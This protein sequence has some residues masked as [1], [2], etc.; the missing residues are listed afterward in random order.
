MRR[1]EGGNR[2]A[3]VGEWD[4]S[5]ENEYN[6]NR[7]VKILI[8]NIIVLIAAAMVIVA[9]DDHDSWADNYV[10]NFAD[11]ITDY[12]GE[13]TTMRLDDGRQFYITSIRADVVSLLGGKAST[14]TPDSAYRCV[15]IYTCSDSTARIANLAP[16]FAPKPVADSVLMSI[17]H[18]IKTDPCRIEGIWRAGEYINARMLVEGH[19][20]SHTAA[21]VDRG[22]TQKADGSRILHLL[23]Y[24][25][26]NGDPEAFTRT[27]YLSCPLMDYRNILTHS[28]ASS[29]YH[30]E[31]ITPHRE[32]PAHPRQSSLYPR[33]ILA[34]PRVSSQY[35]QD[36][37]AHPHDILARPRDSIYFYVNQYDVGLTTFKF[38]Y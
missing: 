26:N 35:P 27:I 18:N 38:P 1:G 31:T 25:D 3:A 10:T 21:F 20:V 5:C 33:Y 2:H 11:V 14:L 12:R 34:R 24:H 28:Q 13:P 17:T 9:C 16:A 32:I 36:V 37:P 19:T 7:L 4:E 15:C 23:L 22:I 6:A 8:R 30:R 29:Q